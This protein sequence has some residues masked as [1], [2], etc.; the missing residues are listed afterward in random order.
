MKNKPEILL[1]MLVVLFACSSAQSRLQNERILADDFERGID[2]WQVDDPMSFRIISSG[3]TT[4][5]NVLSLSPNQT[6]Q[7][8]LLKNS[9]NLNGIRIEGEVLFP[10][11]G[12][13]YFGL[14]YNYN[15]TDDRVDFGCLYVKGNDSY[16]RVNPHR[17]GN[18]SRAL[19]EEYKTDFEGDEKIERNTWYPFKAEVIDS[20]CHFYF[21][22]MDVPKVTFSLHEFSSG[23]IGFKPR[24]AGDEVWIDNVTLTSVNDFGYHGIQK[25]ERIQY[26]PES[27][28][29]DWYS[30]GPLKSRSITTENGAADFEKDL[31][32]DGQTYRWEKFETDGRGCVVV[33]KVSRYSNV[34]KN[35][36][37]ATT[38]QSDEQTESVLKVSSLNDVMV[39]VNNAYAGEI[40]KQQYV[41]YDFNVNEN[42]KG[43]E[44]NINLVKGANDILFFVRGGNYSGDGFYACIE[45]I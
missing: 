11:N 4:H 10:T 3:D 45:G 16:I 14:V 18:A 19:Y 15:K 27:M 23:S 32:I 33:G 21:H 41:W 30:L 37:F 34:Y 7:C 13:N 12:H 43:E 25:P 38:V 42:H 9:A 26:R 6:A 29:T 2:N 39:W 8:V 28:L 35:C 40:Q 5:K 17:D 44:L 22:N 36:Y 20:V 24:F 1:S 31:V